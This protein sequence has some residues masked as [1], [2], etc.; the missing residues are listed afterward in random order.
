MNNM[1]YSEDPQGNVLEEKI[2]TQNTDFNTKYVFLLTSVAALGGLLFGFDIAIITGAVPFIQEHFQLNELQLGWGVSSL[3]VGAIFGAAISGRITDVFGR[4]KILIV[5]ALLF[6]ATSVG[7]GLAP[8]FTMFVIAR[9]LGGLAVGATSILSPMYISEISPPKIR[10]RLVSF[11]QLSI[12]VG[13][14]ISYYINYVLHDIGPNNWRWM[15]ASGGVPSLLFFAFLFW[16]PET[17]R[18]LYKIGRKEEA[19]NI[20]KKISGKRVADVEIGQI[21]QSLKETGS[22]F[23][24]LLRPELRKVLWV[25]FGLA[26]FVQ[27]IGINTILGY[28]PII[29]ESAGWEIDAALFSTFVI[30]FINFLFTLVAIW[31]IDKF[32]RKILYL[33]GSAG[34]TVVLALITI[35]SALGEFEG[36]FALILILAF[37]A[38][39]ASC[40][41]PVFWTLVSEIFPNDVRG[42]AMSVPVFT[43][44]IANAVVV[45]IFPWMLSNAGGTVTFGTLG[46]F[47]GLMLVFTIYYVPET[48]GKTL[49]EIEQYWQS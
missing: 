4:K 26:I 30:G 18:F 9:I 2:E 15:F 42:T 3:L 44:W 1:N 24:I 16:V 21:Q 43:Q 13:I 41:G 33:I 37:I 6:A 46:I 5:V 49:E 36:N 31:A 25:G 22:G 8:T 28:A 32:G 12:V 34:L 27:F 10:G 38:F 11:Y 29:L 47:A 39:F 23:K 20:L 45:F 40:I 48:K 35:F 19:Y 17:P 7:T 14:L